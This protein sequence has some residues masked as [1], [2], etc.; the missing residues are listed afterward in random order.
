MIDPLELEQARADIAAYLNTT[1]AA[2]SAL[3]Q[4][5][6]RTPA[7][8]TGGRTTY[9]E[10]DMGTFPVVVTTAPRQDVRMAPQ[11]EAVTSI[12][13][14]ADWDAP[15]SNE[16]RVTVTYTGTGEQKRLEVVA[17]T[18]RSFTLQ[19]IIECREIG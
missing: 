1:G 18:K 2:G 9:T 17:V 10:T 19:Q 13:L 16:D 5:T 15:V 14:R 11:V 3:M 6:R 7:R 8:T 12:W 4:V